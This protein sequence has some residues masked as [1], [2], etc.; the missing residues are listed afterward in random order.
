M[1]RS[2]V[3][4]FGVDALKY[5]TRIDSIRIGGVTIRDVHATFTGS[6]N[7]DTGEDNLGEVFLEAGLL[8]HLFDEIR[9]NYADSTFTMIREVPDREVSPN[10]AVMSDG[11]PIVRAQADGKP[12]AGVIDTGNGWISWLFASSFPTSEYEQ[13]GT[14]TGTFPE[15]FGGSEWSVPYYSVPLRFP[16]VLQRDEMVIRGTSDKPYRLEAQLRKRPLD[17][18]HPRARLPEPPRVLQRTQHV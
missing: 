14:H 17:G 12:I 6:E 13:L 10:F 9:Y 11:W 1:G 15:E 8:R 7:G 5:E 3:P 16:G 2:I 4:A 18:G